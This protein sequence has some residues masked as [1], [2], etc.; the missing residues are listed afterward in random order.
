MSLLVKIA[1]ATALI[2][3]GFGI[4]A[5]LNPASALSFF[6]LPYPSSPSNRVLI[7]SLLA[8]YGARDI[9]M[10]LAIWSCAAY[11]ARKPLGWVMLSVAAMAV[12]D[13]AVCVKAGTGCEWSHWGYAPMVAILGVALLR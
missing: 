13:G 8:V 11:G 10:G 1:S 6:K 3:V 9:F 7:D 12:V 4:N 2:P 5:F